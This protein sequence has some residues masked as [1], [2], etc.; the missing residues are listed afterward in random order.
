MLNLNLVCLAELILCYRN[1]LSSVSY[2][3]QSVPAV[4]AKHVHTIIY[5]HGMVLVEYVSIAACYLYTVFDSKCQRQTIT[6]CIPRP[7]GGG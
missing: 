7:W 5:L 1:L 4:E 2:Y 6:V 3:M